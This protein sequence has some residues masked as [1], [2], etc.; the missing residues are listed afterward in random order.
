MGA[1]TN[2]PGLQTIFWKFFLNVVFTLCVELPRTHNAAENLR[3]HLTHYIC[4]KA[5][6]VG[7]SNLVL[8]S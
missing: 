5:N 1:W 4:G 8:Y 3:H 2:G 6:A 7:I